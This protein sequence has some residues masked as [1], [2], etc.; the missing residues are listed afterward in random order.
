VGR[1]RRLFEGTD[2][3]AEGRIVDRPKLPALRHR[4]L[5]V[6]GKRRAAP[7]PV[8]DAKTYVLAVAGGRAKVDAGGRRR[9][10]FM[11]VL[12]TDAE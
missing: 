5:S 9:G 4:V 2:A 7:G 12:I 1:H 6:E 10:R 3:D 11:N 8:G